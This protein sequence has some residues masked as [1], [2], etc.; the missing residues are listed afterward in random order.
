MTYLKPVSDKAWWSVT[1]IPSNAWTGNLY[2]SVLWCRRII[3][4]LLKCW[5]HCKSCTIQS[6]IS[7]SPVLCLR[8]LTDI[9]VRHFLPAYFSV[10]ITPIWCAHI[11]ALV[12]NLFFLNI[13]K[14]CFRT[15]DHSHL[16]YNSSFFISYLQNQ[17]VIQ[18]FAHNK[19]LFPEFIKLNS[20]PSSHY[21]PS[22]PQPPRNWFP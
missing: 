4:G 2:D 3:H 5:N 14:S 16:P 15:D 21:S 17:S 18:L 9:S 22:Q 11:C 10:R 20:T 19:A 1:V 6:E 13:K 12:I 8:C 7:G